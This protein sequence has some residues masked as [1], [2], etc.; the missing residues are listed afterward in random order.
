MKRTFL[1]LL[2]VSFL[3]C[4]LAL[5]LPVEAK[6]SETA[7]LHYESACKAENAQNYL[8]AIEQMKKAIEQSPDEALLY[9]KTAGFYSEIGDWQNAL[10]MYK[11]AIK[12]RPNDAFIY[13]SVGNIL[14]QQHKYEDAFSAY[15][16]AS[17]IF[18]DYTYNY[19]NMANVKY[20]M[21]EK[22]E[23]LEYYKTFLNYYPNNID[24]RENVASIYLETD[25]PQND[26]IDVDD[27]EI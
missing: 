2:N 19:L 6:M 20:L 16:Q 22:T 5:S 17:V 15:Q 21:G 12:L 11:K 26:V 24:A 25:E 14:Q 4:A 1:R 7:H 23:A 18:P 13:I 8:Q 9:T 3:T 10:S 27:Y